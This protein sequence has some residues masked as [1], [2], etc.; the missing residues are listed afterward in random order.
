MPAAPTATSSEQA[1]AQA[2]IELGF[3]TTQAL[4]LAATRVE[5]EC[6]EPAQVRRLLDCGCSHDLALRI[7]V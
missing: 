4:M 7:V 3:D 5:G 1:R 2:F 6:V